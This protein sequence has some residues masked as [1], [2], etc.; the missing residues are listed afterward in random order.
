MQLK[1]GPRKVHMSVYLTP[2]MLEDLGVEVETWLVVFACAGA[3]WGKLGQTSRVPSRVV[4]NG[5]LETIWSKRLASNIAQKGMVIRGLI[6][7]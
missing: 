4:P 5:L 2:A 6:M 7:E 3:P 1:R